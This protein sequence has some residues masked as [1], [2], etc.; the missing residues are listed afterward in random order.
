MFPRFQGFRQFLNFCS[1]LS[2]SGSQ[3]HMGPTLM[4]EVSPGQDMTQMFQR[5]QGLSSFLNF[6]SILS[7]SGSQ[8]LMGPTLMS[9]ASV[10]QD[11][12]TNFFSLREQQPNNCSRVQLVCTQC[13]FMVN[14]AFGLK[15]HNV[16]LTLHK[17]WWYF[18]PF[19]YK[20][21]IVVLTLHKMWWYFQP[22]GYKYHISRGHGLG[23]VVLLATIVAKSL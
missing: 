13:S 5:V 15:Y 4:S 14:L 8:M 6:C 2:G 23:M 18:Q 1:I 7:G 16:V 10:G 17:M 22:F 20:Y 9:V 12:E 3:M 11:H 21:H 19:G